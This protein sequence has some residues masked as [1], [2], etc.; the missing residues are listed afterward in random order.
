M[1]RGYRV[2]AVIAGLAVIGAIAWG[3]IASN[4]EQPEYRV[5]RGDDALAVRA[6]G[7]RIVAEAVVEGEREEA[8]NAGFRLIA[9]YIFGNN[10]AAENVPMTA[11]V[12]QQ[13]AETIA[14]T[15]PVLQQSRGDAGSAPSWRVQFI[16]PARYTL[17]TLPVPKN[18][19]VRLA[20]VPAQ[21]YAVI[22]FS[23]IADSETLAKKREALDAYVKR[24][25]LRV[26]GEPIYAFYN[27]PFTLPPLRRNEIMVAT[28][29]VD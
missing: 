9:D 18:D 24:E 15:A 6:Y 2:L 27:P 29:A 11:P 4:V 28:Q 8:I 14:M 10:V 25:G 13:P 21:Q 26:M 17:E 20:T 3:P 12:T 5:V 1:R 22:R 7:P 19:A 16:M 23:G